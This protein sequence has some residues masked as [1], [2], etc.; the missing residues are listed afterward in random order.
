MPFVAYERNSMRHSPVPT[1][2]INPSGAIVINTA[3]V[4]AFNLQ[5]S[6]YATLM[7]D[8]DARRIAIKFHTSYVKG[9]MKIAHPPGSFSYALCSTG[10][11][12]FFKLDF[13][14]ESRYYTPTWN[15]VMGAVIIQL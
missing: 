8:V 9:A 14:K 6:E 5:G 1:A 11:R 15:P 2:S 13:G 10:F 7:Y 3:A 4:C 12:S